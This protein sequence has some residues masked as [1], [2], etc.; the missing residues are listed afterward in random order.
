M[1]F[2]SRMSTYEIDMLIQL[3]L[4]PLPDVPCSSQNV[5]EK[6]LGRPYPIL[7]RQCFS[8]LRHAMIGG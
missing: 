5:G 3:R 4:Y 8:W 6:L 2:F 7:F 1:S